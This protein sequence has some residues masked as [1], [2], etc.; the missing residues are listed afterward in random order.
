MARSYGSRHNARA[1]LLDIPLMTNLRTRSPQHLS[2]QH[3]IAEVA[4][5][6]AKA[7]VRL[8]NLNG[9]NGKLDDIPLAF[10]QERSGND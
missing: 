10:Q 3:R 2:A 8:R 4:R 7:I 9:E 1:T 5:L 6:L